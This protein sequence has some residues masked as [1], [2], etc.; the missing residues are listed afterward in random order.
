MEDDGFVVKNDS[1]SID[2]SLFIDEGESEIDKELRDLLKEMEECD[3]VDAEEEEEEDSEEEEDVEKEEEERRR[4]SRRRRRKT[5]DKVETLRRIVK[6]FEACAN[7]ELEVTDDWSHAD[8]SE[9]A[10]EIRIRRIRTEKSLKAHRRLIFF[11]K[12]YAHAVQREARGK[13]CT[14]FTMTCL[15]G[16]CWTGTWTVYNSRMSPANIAGLVFMMWMTIATTYA[17][18]HSIWVSH[19]KSRELR[20]VFTYRRQI[21]ERIRALRTSQERETENERERKRLDAFPTS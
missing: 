18:A 11:V 15:A 8:L 10:S 9:T 13:V 19:A 5:G 12:K 14:A 7:V 20:A 21:L 3:A 4:K 6:R 2:S 1:A 17:T 16:M